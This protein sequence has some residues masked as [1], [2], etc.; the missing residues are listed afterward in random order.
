MLYQEFS[1]ELNHYLDVY[2]KGLKKQANKIVEHTVILLKDSELQEVDSI[3][4][5]FLTEYCDQ[6]I[7]SVLAKRGNGDIPFALKEFIR[8][9]ITVRCE[10]KNMPELRW[11]YELF[12]N[13]R[14]GYKYARG[15]LDDAY[16][17]EKCDQKT[18]DLL[19][20]SYLELLAWGAHHFPD[21]CI[22]EKSTQDNAI[23]T[24]ERIME[25]KNVNEHL[26]HELYYYKSLY[27][28]YEKYVEDGK[29]KDF[30]VYCKD[31]NLEFHYN[32]A[33]YY[34]RI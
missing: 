3:M 16:N 14:I 27:D 13:D 24:C 7:W 32:K 11:Y 4:F 8:T 9:W 17:S 12:R 29:V 1:D 21:G 6:E 34:E 28:C 26:V 2:E 31:C 19:F 25:E 10:K 5:R 23:R 22:I 15:Y 20:D 18:V 30:E 33:F